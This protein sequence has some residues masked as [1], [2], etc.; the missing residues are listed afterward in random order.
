MRSIRSF[1]RTS[2]A[3]AA[4]SAVGLTLTASPAQADVNLGGRFIA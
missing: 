2:C 4:V 3:I 1:I